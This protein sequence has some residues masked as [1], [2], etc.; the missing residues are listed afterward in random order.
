[1][2]ADRRAAAPLYRA[3]IPLGAGMIS[4][5]SQFDV[6]RF[7]NSRGSLRLIS[8]LICRPPWGWSL[9]RCCVLVRRAPRLDHLR[10]VRPNCIAHSIRSWFAVSRHIFL[11]TTS[12]P[13]SADSKNGLLSYEK[14]LRGCGKAGG[15]VKL[16]W[17]K[18][19]LTAASSHLPYRYCR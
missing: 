16:S 11:E 4:P 1:V 17:A 9:P 6:A 7:F 2:G 10:P 14:E 19:Q 12:P 5:V 18:A 13:H 3:R 8:S 15:I